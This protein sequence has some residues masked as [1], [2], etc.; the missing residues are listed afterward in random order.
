VDDSDALPD[1]ISHTRINSITTAKVF[2]F[3][4]MNEFSE[5]LK[6]ERE[7]L[8]HPNGTLREH[9]RERVSSSSS[10]AYTKIYTWHIP[11]LHLAY[12]KSVLGIF[13]SALGL[14]QSAL[15]IKSVLGIYQICTWDIPNLHLVCAKSVLGIY[16]ICT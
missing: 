15:G 3:C 1:P 9:C 5:E 16:Q 11:H 6:E 13:Q 7:C 4:D 2:Q 10:L 14:F 12:T 8:L